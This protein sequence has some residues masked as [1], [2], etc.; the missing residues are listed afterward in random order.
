MTTNMRG[1]G[2]EHLSRLAALVRKVDEGVVDLMCVCETKLTY[3]HIPAIKTLRK[4]HPGVILKMCHPAERGRRGVLAIW[5]VDMPFQHPRAR[6]DGNA[7]RC[8]SLHFRAAGGHE[9]SVLCAYLE[10]AHAP[11]EEKTRFFEYL[12]NHIPGRQK[13]NHACICL[14][15][16]N[17][18]M[19]E[20]TQR[21]P[22]REGPRQNG[23]LLTFARGHGLTELVTY[24]HPNAPV[25]TWAKEDGTAK[26]KVDHLF[27][28]DAARHSYVACGWTLINP[29][30]HTDHGVVWAAFDMEKLK[31]V[32]AAPARRARP[33]DMPIMEK[34]ANAYTH[35]RHPGYPL[36]MKLAT[37]PGPQRRHRLNAKEL[38]TALLHSGYDST[39]LIT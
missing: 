26:S 6:W 9:L 17:M 35:D 12:G 21:D 14:G 32:R 13:A 19:N 8:L 16:F 31:P 10:D 33:M 18:T 3:K 29:F 1:Q 23:E 39:R 11:S 27:V 7:N 37:P 36:R 30:I 28:N 5:R 25:Y 15:D 34:G 24:V 2:C 22:P 20:N 4:R 38:A